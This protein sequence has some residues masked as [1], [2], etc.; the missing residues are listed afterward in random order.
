MKYCKFIFLIIF[1]ILAIYYV[2][3]YDG[4]G[5]G[6]YLDDDGPPL[7]SIEFDGI[8]IVD[9]EV[10]DYAFDS[11]YIIVYRKIND[12]LDNSIDDYNY[13]KKN[14]TNYEYWIIDKINHRNYGH[15]NYDA[16]IEKRSVLLISKKLLLDTTKNRLY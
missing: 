9:N 8:I 2:K 15:L 3:I 6:Y 5:R 16:F 11:K 7:V 1:I 4:L 14:G 10:V 13:K 12:D